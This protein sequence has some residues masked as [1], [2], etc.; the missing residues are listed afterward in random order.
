LLT[1]WEVNKTEWLIKAF[2]VIVVKR[3]QAGNG[4]T[5]TGLPRVFA[6]GTPILASDRVF[7]YKE[8]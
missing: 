2:D 4:S 5:K 7:V 1:P 3:E 8:I 6:S